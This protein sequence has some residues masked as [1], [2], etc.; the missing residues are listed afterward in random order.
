MRGIAMHTQSR[1]SDCVCRVVDEENS[2]QVRDEIA[3]DLHTL[4]HELKLEIRDS[5]DVPTGSREA[6]HEP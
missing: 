3:K 6:L 2:F 5:S 1:E 4:R